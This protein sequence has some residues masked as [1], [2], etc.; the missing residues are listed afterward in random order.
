MSEE[1]EFNTEVMRATQRLLHKHKEELQKVL[2]AIA[3]K[4]GF[5]LAYWGYTID[6]SFE[7]RP[8]EREIDRA[9]VYYVSEAIWEEEDESKLV[10]RKLAELEREVKK[11][12]QKLYSW[13]EI[14]KRMNL[15]DELKI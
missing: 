4:Y 14:K 9:S 5:D 3:G 11:G 13:D 7:W 8:S 6:Y 15:K 1:E 2:E 12:K 10:A